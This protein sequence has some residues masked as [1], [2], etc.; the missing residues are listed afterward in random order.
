MEEMEQAFKK[1]REPN[2]WISIID[3]LSGG[4]ITKHEEIYKTNYIHS[5]NM[6]SY[7]RQTK[8]NDNTK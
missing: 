7:W 3:K 1:E 5:L 6:L 8:E 4:D 2:K